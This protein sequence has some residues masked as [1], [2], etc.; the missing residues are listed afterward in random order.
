MRNATGGG[1]AAPAIPKVEEEAEADEAG[2]TVLTV[3]GGLLD[4]DAVGVHCLVFKPYEDR[5]KTMGKMSTAASAAQ[6]QRQSLRDSLMPTGRIQYP[7]WTAPEDF[8]LLSDTP[9]F[10][11]TF[12]P[13][14][15]L[16]LEAPDPSLADASPNTPSAARSCSAYA[17]A[18]ASHLQPKKLSLP[19]DL[20]LVGHSRMT[21]AQTDTCGISA[22][23]SLVNIRAANEAPYAPI[24]GGQAMPRLHQH[25]NKQTL[26]A[27]LRTPRI[28]TSTHVDR[29]VRFWDISSSLLTNAREAEDGSQ[30][31]VHAYPKHLCTIDMMS[32]LMATNILTASKV[33]QTTPELVFISSVSSAFEVGEVAV[34]LSSG[35]C[36]IFRLGIDS[37]EPIHSPSAPSAPAD[38]PM[39]PVSPT[40]LGGRL[41]SPAPSQDSH[42]KG[43]SSSSRMKS[44]FGKANF[45]KR[46]SGSVSSKPGLRSSQSQPQPAS[47]SVEDVTISDLSAAPQPPPG[48]LAFRPAYCI[49]RHQSVESCSTSL[50]DT[51]FLAIGWADGGLTLVD[52]RGPDCIYHK[53][54][55]G[56]RAAV[57]EWAV[58]PSGEDLRPLPRLYACLYANPHSLSLGSQLKFSWAAPRVRYDSSP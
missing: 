45:L 48:V 41:P 22:L 2:V 50:T 4:N 46:S 35:E 24:K 17:F 52:L 56:E 6:V 51:G 34:S 11:G 18:R 44:A 37:P 26:A 49:A 55:R 7:T 21:S 47:A 39:S 10:G 14:A 8:C 32:L 30:M 58:A 53:T 29:S 19:P 1:A 38:P 28:L 13:T 15:I 27:G 57:L 3:L 40:E 54:F 16:I 12:D 20:E 36:I 31:L 33:W 5:S 43:G 42:G 25:A 9:W 23:Q